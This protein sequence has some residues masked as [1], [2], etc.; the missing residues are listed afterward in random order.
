MKTKNRTCRY[1]FLIMGA[2]LILTNSC[3]KDEAENNPAS[4]TDKDGNVYTSVTIGTQVWMVENL[5]TTKYN[6]GTPI[7]NVT[8]NT[9]W[10]NLTTPAYCWY[11]NDITKK[12][13]Y[14]AL[15]NGYAVRSGK[16]CPTGWHVPSDTEW[17]TLFDH[18]GGLNVAGGK[19]KE[20]GTSHWNSPN[21][22]A[23]DEYGFKYLPGGLRDTY[24]SIYS[25]GVVGDYWGIDSQASGY[26]YSV[27][28]FYNDITVGTTYY[29][30]SND[31]ISVR[32]LQD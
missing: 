22:G 7:P 17:V 15:Y 25:I 29:G 5:K 18:A 6:D 19:L 11:D 27:G 32:C 31:G 10:S 14:G 4:I 30:I 8:D 2:I 16:L 9:E 12:N 26:Q 20:T 24:G 21:T 1:P 3:K 13:P 28:I 23:T